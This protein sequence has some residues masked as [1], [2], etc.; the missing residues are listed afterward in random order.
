MFDIHSHILHDI[1]DGAKDLTESIALLEEMK[2]QGITSVLATPHFYPHSDF[3][4]EFLENTH[5]N[6]EE[7]KKSCQNKNLP[8][9]YLGCEVFY[10]SGISKA[11]NIQKLTLNS[12]NYMLLEPHPMQLGLGF[13]KELLYLRDTLGITPIIA[14]LER[15]RKEKGYRKLLDF[16]KENNILVQVNTSSLLNFK[17]RG[18]LK[19]L[20]KSDL[21]TFLGTDTHSLEHRPPQFLEAIQKLEKMFGSEYKEKLITNSLN[22]LK[23]ITE[24]GN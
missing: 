19:K 2:A 20:I 16:I 8:N 13:Q 21:V 22:L 3:L 5:K 18:A 11:D 24:K 15:Y 9:I 4:D 23:Q 1:D 6:F 7:L 10:Y 17:C 14:H 12:S